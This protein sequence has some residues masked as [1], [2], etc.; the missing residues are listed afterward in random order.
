MRSAVFHCRALCGAA[1]LAAAAC[2]PGPDTLPNPDPVPD[3]FVLYERMS[4][5]WDGAGN[6]RFR[7][8]DGAL[9]PGTSLV[10]YDDD[11]Q[12]Q[13]HEVTPEADGRFD[14]MLGGSLNQVYLVV[15]KRGTQTGI[16]TRFRARKPVD[17]LR[18]SVQPRRAGTGS[19]PNQ[20][21]T[22]LDASTT[23]STRAYVVLS[24]DNLVDNV[25]WDSGDRTGPVVALPETA[26]ALGPVP[27]TPWAMV[28]RGNRGFVS[29]YSQGRL[30]ALDLDE[31]TVLG[32]TDAVSPVALPQATTVSPPADWDGDGQPEDTATAVL[33]RNP[34]GLAVMGDWAY[35]AFANVLSTVSSGTARYAPGMV[36]AFRLASDGRPT[37]ETRATFTRW[38]N[39]QHVVPHPDGAH[40]L[41]SCTGE[42]QRNGEVWTTGP[43]GVD[44]LDADTLASTAG[45]AL[46][47]FAPSRPLVLPDGHSVYVPSVLRARLARLDLATGAVVA[48]PG[49]AADAVHVEDTDQLSTVFE[50][51]LHPT[52]LVF[53]GVFDTDSLVVVDPQ[54]DAVRPFP[55]VA[56][57]NLS[58]LS[59]NIRL[60][61]QSLSIRPGRNG[62]DRTGADILILLSL[63]SR[64]A[65]VD[66][67]FILGP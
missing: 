22:A 17:V 40:V 20:V 11:T 60:G 13:L 42:L 36:V 64:V 3:T 25:D 55:F 9:P 63:A 54:G 10:V 61:V 30:A 18:Q 49:G 47:E 14:V 38:P 6:A 12:Q 28:A 48:G 62:V 45:F 4:L 7:G 66:T 35:V 56:P 44:V 5:L 26:S 67:R 46:P 2:T 16:S 53:C 57:I 39:P 37:G 52:G 58:E 19:T 21:V 15:P 65:A 34:G 32:T 50:C 33:P 29:L 27:A 43:S 31:G 8:F 24:G 59:G 1:L 51:A 23:G 41:V